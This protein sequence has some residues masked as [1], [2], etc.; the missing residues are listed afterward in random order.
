MSVYDDDDFEDDDPDA[1]GNALQQLRKANK[2]KDR[3]L[4]ELTEQLQSMQK[5]LRERS[6]RDV[7][8]AKGLPDKIAAFIPESATT[9]DEVEAWITEYGD[10]FGVQQQQADQPASS[11]QQSDPTLDALGRISQ[12]Q[13]SGQPFTNDP[14]QLSALIKSA[15]NPEELNRLLFGSATGPQAV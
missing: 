4:K 11:P 8:A 2:A 1:G 6:V 5:S 9:S 10:V 14:D 13:S 15:S 7:L 12:V 3:Q